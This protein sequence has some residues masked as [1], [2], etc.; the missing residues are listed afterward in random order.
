MSVTCGLTP[1]LKRPYACFNEWFSNYCKSFVM[2]Y[3]T[4]EM[5][6]TVQVR[7]Y[8]LIVALFLSTISEW[9]FSFL[10]GTIHSN[11]THLFL[12]SSL[13]QI[14]NHDGKCRCKKHAQQIHNYWNGTNYDSL[15]IKRAVIHVIRYILK[16]YVSFIKNCV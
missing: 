3:N 5:W 13:W 6:Q 4:K 15:E 8:A 7:K 14:Y 16:C 9:N 11:S 2:V 12:M 1:T 10:F